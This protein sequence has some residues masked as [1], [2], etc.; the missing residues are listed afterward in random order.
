MPSAINPVQE[1]D[2]R[3]KKRLHGILKVNSQWTWEEEE[4]NS[5]EKET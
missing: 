1:V 4:G 3:R 2:I 5:A